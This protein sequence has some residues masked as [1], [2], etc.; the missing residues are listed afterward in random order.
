MIKTISLI[1]ITTSLS[2][3]GCGQNSEEAKEEVISMQQAGK[4]ERVNSEKFETLLLKYPDAQLVDVRTA[5]EYNSGHLK[6]AVNMDYN[7]P[8]FNTKVGELKKDKPVF[9]YCAAG[10][11]SS[12]ASYILKDKGFT[13]VIDLEGGIANWEKSGKSIKQD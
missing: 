8:S 6:G 12:A 1:M 11:R 10:G 7:S 3:A 13:H 2:L 4:M 9:V 5:R